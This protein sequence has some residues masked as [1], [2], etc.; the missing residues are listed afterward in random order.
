MLQLTGNVTMDPR[1]GPHILPGHN[2]CG[3]VNSNIQTLTPQACKPQP[4]RDTLEV[5]SQLP[6]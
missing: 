5:E 4:A 2:G 1:S 6:S 3:N